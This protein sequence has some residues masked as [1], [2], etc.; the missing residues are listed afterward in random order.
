MN[1]ANF[2][3]LGKTE[4]LI[5]AVD[6]S[7]HCEG[8]IREAITFAKKCSSRIFV[9]RVLDVNLAY[10][11]A[12]VEEETIGYLNSIKTKAVQE[13]LECETIL[14]YGE[15]PHLLIVDEAS[16]RKAD[17]IIVGRHG[18]RGLMRLMMGQVAAKVI[19]FAP[20][21]VLVVPKTAKINYRNILVATDGSMHGDAAAAETVGIA[22][23][24]GSSIIA[25]SA[26]HS[27]EEMG[28]AA[29]NVK[30][31]VDMAQS[32]GVPAETHTPKGKP[33]E[34]IV[35]TASGRGVDLIVMGAYGT[36]DL[37]RL[38]MGSATERV[39]GLAGCAVL[40]VKA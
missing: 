27:D 13:G 4:T 10:D 29:W 18:R 1:G 26:V 6:G 40:V 35:E 20:C 8:A 37:R 5:L 22:K 17:M 24:C 32:E 16:K 31:V 14:H 21:K 28:D 12:G 23:K 30:R 39:I 38:L 34:V 15:E 11:T 36:T 9:V 7:E 2:C 33:Y 19:G 25:L 3:P